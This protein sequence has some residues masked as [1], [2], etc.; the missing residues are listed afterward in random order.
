[1]KDFTEFP[2]LIIINPFGRGGSIF[3]QSL[4]DG[5]PNIV[6][7]PSFGP[8]YSKISYKVFTDENIFN[9]EVEKFIS[10]NED[11]FDTSKGYFGKGKGY[12]S[13]SFGQNANEHIV[14]DVNLFKK[15]INELKI[16]YFNDIKF[17]P[18]KFFFTLIHLS[19]YEIYYG[20]CNNVRYL[21]Y[22]PHNFFELRYLIK[23]FP[24]LYFIGLSRNPLSDWNSWKK[25]LSTRLNV[26]IKRIN[27]MH[28][29][30]NVFNYCR[31]IYLFSLIKD[32]I[33]NKKIIDLIFLHK[34]NIILM[35]KISIW[36]KIDFHKSLLISTFC[37]KVWAGNYADRSIKSSFDS[38]R[39]DS[40]NEL[41]S[42]EKDFIILNSFIPANFLNYKILTKKISYI[43]KIKFHFSMILINFY[44][45]K[46][47]SNYNI[48]KEISI[49]NNDKSNSKL[50]KVC[51]IYFFNM[52][53]K[54]AY[55]FL[56]NKTKKKLKKLNYINSVINKKK[57]N[58][59]SFFV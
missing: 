21:L 49:I 32:K 15:K 50:I 55:F 6:T 54:F 38:K 42:F 46:T 45:S 4:L 28:T 5:H 56:K 33:N 27:F 1:M 30:N 2:N 34:Q 40:T 17:I 22:H 24:N 41:S 51:K 57:L 52:T 13:G 3:F 53:L 9:N 18:R 10:I 11:I 19:F 23:D 48:K 43:T 25:V 14:T 39:K 29:F 8:I 7:L 58:A 31:D 47:S 59:D 16:K 36:L 44:R 26:K 37:N 20:N 35:K 12:A